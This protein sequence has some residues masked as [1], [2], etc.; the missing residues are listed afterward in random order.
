MATDF[1]LTTIIRGRSK[2]RFLDGAAIETWKIQGNEEE[3]AIT[4]P[5]CNGKVRTYINGTLGDLFSL[6][7]VISLMKSLISS[8]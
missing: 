3:S 1:K 6:P 7:S 8:S 4:C 2:P 5:K